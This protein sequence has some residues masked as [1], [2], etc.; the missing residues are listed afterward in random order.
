MKRPRRA[1]RGE[2]ALQHRLGL[3]AA[4]GQ[5]VGLAQVRGVAHWTRGLDLRAARVGEGW[6]GDGTG[7]RPLAGRDGRGHDPSPYTGP[8]PIVT[9]V[10]GAVDGGAA[11]AGDEG[12]YDAEEEAWEYSAVGDGRQAWRGLGRIS[13]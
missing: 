8:V 5:D 9:H 12:R 13:I 10:H 2:Q 7:R 6:A 11:A 4:V 3:G 1:A